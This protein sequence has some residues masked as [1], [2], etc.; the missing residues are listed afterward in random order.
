MRNINLNTNLMY[1]QTLLLSSS[2]GLL[3]GLAATGLL[4]TNGRIAGIS[5]I[6]AGLL[7]PHHHEITWRACFLAGLLA[8]GILLQWFY[9]AAFSA[10]HPHGLPIIAAGGLLVGL[11]AR[12]S[13]GCTSGHGVC[14][15]ARRS[16]R[17]LLATLTFMGSALVTVFV[18]HHPG[19]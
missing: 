6:L 5:N 3:I 2:G 19:S 10:H 8:G 11:G 4:L 7:H 15:L 13:N 9:P 17:S 1:V 16:L 18:L 14:G 12:W